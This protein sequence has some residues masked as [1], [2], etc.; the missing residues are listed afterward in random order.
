MERRIIILLCAAAL[1]GC[2]KEITP[3]DVTTQESAVLEPTPMTVRAESAKTVLTEGSKV[4]WQ[5]DDAISIFDSQGNRK[6]I[7]DVGGETASFSGSAIREDEKY[8]LY[9]YQEF[10]RMDQKGVIRA[11]IP[12]SQQA[13][14][15][16][17]GQGNNFTA[18][19][20]DGDGFFALNVCS[21]LKVKISRNDVVSIDVI[22]NNGTAVL[23]GIALIS[24]PNAGYPSVSADEGS[25]SVSL[26]HADG[27]TKIEAGTYYIDA[28]P[29]TL[30]NGYRIR[31]TFT[32]GNYSDKTVS[33][34]T[35]FERSRIFDLGEVNDSWENNGIVL[36][37]L[38]HNGT[39]IVQPFTT[40]MPTSPVKTQCTYHL[41][42]GGSDYTFEIYSP[43]YGHMLSNDKDFKGLRLS[44][45]NVSA[46][47]KLPAIANRGLRSIGITSGSSMSNKKTFLVTSSITD[48]GIN[49]PLLSLK[50]GGGSNPETVTLGLDSYDKGKSYYIYL[51]ASSNP[52]A[53]IKEINLYY[54]NEDS[55]S[56]I[57]PYW[58]KAKNQGEKD[59]SMCNLTLTVN[60]IPGF[61]PVG[62]PDTD[63]YGGWVG[64][65]TF[66]ATGWFYCS[67][68]NGRWWMVDPLGNPFISKG[69][70][71]FRLDLGSDTAKNAFKDKYNSNYTLW[72][73]GEWNMLKSYGFNSF[74][75]F[76]R[77]S[78]IKNDLRV[79]Y[80]VLIT[81][82]SSWREKLKKEGKYSSVPDS[83]WDSFGPYGI[84]MVFEDGWA[85]Y[86]NERIGSQIS[87]NKYDT[88]QFIMGF[89]TDNEFPVENTFLKNCLQ[90][91]S[92]GERYHD[93]A[94]NWLEEQGIPEASGI[95]DIDVQRRFAAFLYE[96]YLCQV[97]AAIKKYAPNHMYQGSKLTGNNHGLSNPYAFSVLG[98]YCDAISVDYYHVWTPSSAKLEMW[99][100]Q[101]GKPLILAEW[102]VKGED[103][104]LPNTTGVGYTVPTQTDR[105]RYYQNYIIGALKNKSVVGWH[106]FRYMDND[107]EDASATSSNIDANKGVVKVNMDR[108]TGILDQMKM[109]NNNVYPLC[110]F[111]DK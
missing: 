57:G 99:S 19:K 100:E 102:Y 48:G 13:T 4:Y 11:L 80:T 39:S 5:K 52:N 95:N 51:P 77:I 55:G 25:H 83:E 82:A 103:S 30:N 21:L 66:P 23:S 108:Y 62:E 46:W 53:V 75:S 7:S 12:G 88:D 37:V 26:V 104:G 31:A 49:D 74:G 56:D 111:L 71:G 61:C 38:F 97:S 32:D 40:T 20:L 60:D 87:S 3:S 81:V 9:P 2:T 14:K 78:S 44:G 107:P 70:C 33:S 72:A 22:D 69:L 79:P 8:M 34:N 58:I 10:A 18:A 86:A 29:C 6:F 17:F 89:M 35:V 73:E 28:I 54:S 101:S 65:F 27:E 16:S 1:C 24:I 92:A 59:W 63:E 93:V 84:P 15:S 91:F 109:L 85:A 42:Q 110:Q 106:W 64:T 43:S 96:A 98:T 36:N 45:S 47:I 94:A 105:G 68:H 67:Q 76:S 41:N 50:V 90:K